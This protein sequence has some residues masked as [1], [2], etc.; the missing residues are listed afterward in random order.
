[1]ARYDSGNIFV[2]FDFYSQESE[3]EIIEYLL[4]PNSDIT[5][6]DIYG[7][8]ILHKICC[9]DK[10]ENVLN[11]LL[12]KGDISFLIKDYN[13]NCETSLHICARSRRS[14]KILQILLEKYP[15]TIDLNMKD[16]PNTPLIQSIIYENFDC[17]K[18]L[19]DFGADISIKMN[20]KQ[21]AMDYLLAIKEEYEGVSEIYNKFVEYI[22]QNEIILKEPMEF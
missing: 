13:S 3:N 4:N 20:K 22:Q 15:E 7:N 8:N 17:F 10:W 9:S 12:G 21:N 1:M 14:S 19:I 2:H 11:V 16:F 5:I 6:K 18:I